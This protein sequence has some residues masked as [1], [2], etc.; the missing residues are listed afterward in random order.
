M[1]ILVADKFEK[2]GLDGLAATG[3]DV[4]FEPDLRD[5]ALGDR[6]AE[7]GAEI[8][9]VRSTKVTAPIL[10]KAR[11]TALVIRA[12]A[13]VN[14]ID[15]AAASRQGVFVANCPGKNGIAV[16]ELA[17]GLMLALDRRIPD[18]AEALRRGEWNKKEFAKAKGIFGRTLGIAGTGTIGREVAARARAFG[19]KVLGWSRSLTDAKAEAL[20][21]E[22]VGDVVELARRCDVVSVHLAAAPETKGLFGAE[23]FAAMRPGAF[24]VNTARADV[25]DPAAL[26]AALDRGIRAGLDVFPK[27]PAESKGAFESPLARHPNVVGTHHI[28]AS[29]DQAQEAIAAETVRLV[30]AY[31]ETG[32]VDNV[33]NLARRPPA[34]HLLVVRHRDRVGVLAHVLAAL[35]NDGISVQGME[36]TV[37]E[38]AEAACARIE[39][40]KEPRE[41]T[42]DA[43]RSGSEDIFSLSVTP[44]R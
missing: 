11:G 5:D 19:M 33:V 23:F 26:L 29:T 27:E 38:G 16:A 41:G 35:K 37:F 2:S 25:V 3:S 8:L 40:D 39:L 36:N 42:L 21:I 1:K 32:K 20:G 13:G 9:I 28:G 14:T 15:L 18:N 43:I 24:F 44:L 31:I 10:E 22:R 4:L 34:T 30:R 12:G 6:L 7:T 17:M